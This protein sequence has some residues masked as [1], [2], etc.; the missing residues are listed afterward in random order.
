MLTNPTIEKLRALKLT[1]MI[2]ALEEQMSLE[3]V[4][5]LDFFER[6]GLLVDREIV[7][8]DNRRLKTRL[9]A[10]KLREPATIED[11]NYR[12]PRGLDRSLMASL[13]SCSWIGSARNVIITG[14]TG[15]GKTYISCAL[16]QKAMREGYRALYRR[17]PRLLRELS[18]AHA[19]GSYPKAMTGLAKS[20][21][22]V[23]DD[24]GLTALAADQERDLLE[25]IEDR[26]GLHSTIIT[27]QLPV[28]AW[29]EQMSNPT[30]ADAILD[31]L[32][33]NAYR[34]NLNGESMRKAYAKET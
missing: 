4:N 23:L 29:H 19:D 9:R 22:L 10:A 8:R 33:H 34:I 6:L 28:E 16:A 11:I 5:D 25:I 24:W 20:H 18:V 2:K 3:G 21:L 13:A 30:V 32:V 31:R 1:G 27:S 15:A 17:T 14:P 12:H 26:H 7:E